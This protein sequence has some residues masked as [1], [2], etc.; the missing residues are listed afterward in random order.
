MLFCVWG[1]TLGSVLV[2]LSQSTKT[3]CVCIVIFV[4]HSLLFVDPCSA[5]WVISFTYL[6]SADPCSALWVILFTYLCSAD[7]CSALWVISF[8]YLCSADICSALW[9]ILFTYL[10]SADIC[11]A[12]WVISLCS[13]DLWSEYTADICSCVCGRLCPILYECLVVWRLTLN[14]SVRQFE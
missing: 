7:P 8:T 14:R 10:C 3:A 5:L 4:G 1:L 13:A 12:L 6:C 2:C 9:V 11:S